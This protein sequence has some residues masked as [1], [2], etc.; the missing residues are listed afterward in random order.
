MKQFH[1]F[2][3]SFALVMIHNERQEN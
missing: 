1:V 3:I 2:V